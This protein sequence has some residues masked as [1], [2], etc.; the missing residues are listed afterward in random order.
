MHK[1][2]SCSYINTAPDCLVMCILPAANVVHACACAWH[3]T[4]LLEPVCGQ[5][6]SVTHFLMYMY[7]RKFTKVANMA[8]DDCICSV[9]EQNEAPQDKTKPPT[10]QKQAE[11]QPITPGAR[12]EQKTSASAQRG[13]GAGKVASRQAILQLPRPLAQPSRA[14]AA[15]TVKGVLNRMPQVASL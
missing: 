6:P 7:P 13:S 15:A 5:C 2:R 3:T 12:Q 9:Q 11:A 1:R 8:L 4:H 14:P 10:V